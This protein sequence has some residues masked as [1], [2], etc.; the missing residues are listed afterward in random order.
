MRLSMR[1][2]R[3]RRTP[4]T[5][6]TRCSASSRAGVYEALREESLEALKTIG[7]DGYAIGGLAV[8]EPKEERSQHPRAH[9]TAPAR[10]TGRA[11]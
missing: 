2:A 4:V 3:A 6:A 7:F 1:W 11:T 10:R 5:A 9:G 8:G